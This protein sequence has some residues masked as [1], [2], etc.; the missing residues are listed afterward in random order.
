MKR[1]QGHARLLL[2][3]LSLARLLLAIAA[4]TF[5][6]LASAA[7]V[8]IAGGDLDPGQPRADVY[9][10][11]PPSAQPPAGA[12]CALAKTYVDYVRAGR[13]A[14]MAGLFTPDAALLEPT[15]QNVRGG[16]AIARFY[17]TTIG[18]MRPD[19]IA[20]FYLGDQTDCLVELAVRTM[21]DGAPRY[22]LASVDHFTVDSSGK[23]VRMVAFARP[24]DLGLKPP[25]LA[26]PP[27]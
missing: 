15:R 21:I 22:R 24:S 7:P 3:R 5:S 13:F 11:T 8:T 27:R 20:V 17:Q 26:P 2:A 23:A 1:R 14:E 18:A 10:A 12:A 16:A 4:S 19:L 9:L 25:G 6:A